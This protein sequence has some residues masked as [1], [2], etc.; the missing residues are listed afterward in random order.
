[1]WIQPSLGVEAEG[2]YTWSGV[3][4][5]FDDPQSPGSFSLNATLLAASGRI[6]Y[7]PART[8]FHVFGGA[9]IVHR[10]GDFWDFLEANVFGAPIDKLTTIGGVV[11]FGVRAA[12]T[13]G[14]ALNVTAEA[15][16]SKFDPESGGSAVFNKTNGQPDVVVT[17]GVPFS[18]V[19]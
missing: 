1:V 15:Y 16:L 18:L 19:K 3:R 12:V 4:I 14:L 17:I 6:L 11:G 10:A 8:N 9:G 5:F 2:V 7:R 13:P